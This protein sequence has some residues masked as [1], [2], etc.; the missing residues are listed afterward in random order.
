MSR[1]LIDDN[2]G[3]S[4]NLT[5]GS[6]DANFASL[7]AGPTSLDSLSANS[8]TFENITVLDTATI[9]LLITEQELK[10]ED[11]LIEFG[12][13]NP[14]DAVNLGIIEHYNDGAAKYTG[15]IRDRVTKKQYLYKDASVKPT[16]TTD[17]ST[18]PRGSLVCGDIETAGLSIGSQYTLPQTQ[19]AAGQVLT[20][21][22][23]DG[24]LSWQDSQGGASTLQE[25]YDNSTAPQIETDLINPRLT[26]KQ[27]AA[28]SNI[29]MTVA[30]SSGQDNIAMSANGDISSAGTINADTREQQG[31]AG[32]LARTGIGS[33]QNIIV[34]ED[35][36]LDYSILTGNVIIGDG[37]SKVCS[38]ENTVVGT[39]AGQNLAEGKSVLVGF[40]SGMEQT[41]GFNVAAGHGALEGTTGA[42]S[43]RCVAAGYEAMH[44][45]NTASDTVAIGHQA[46]F[47][48]NSDGCVLLGS[49]TSA[50]ADLCTAIGFGAS[51][52]DPQTTVIGSS[53][54]ATTALA[55]LPGIDDTTDLGAGNLVY[56]NAFVKQAVLG[57]LG[58]E[59]VLPSVRGLEGQTLRSLGANAVDWEYIGLQQAFDRGNLI[60]TDATSNQLQIRK[61]PA[62]PTPEL[63][64]LQDISGAQVMS[65][66]STGEL[67]IGM[68]ATN[69]KLPVAR[70]TDKQILQTDANGQVTW[71]SLPEPS[72][73]EQYF[74]GNIVVTDITVQNQYFV[75]AGTRVPGNLKDFVSNATDLEYTGAETRVMKFDFSA[76][77][78]IDDAKQKDFE[79]GIHKNGVLQPEGVMLFV[80]DDTNQYPRVICTSCLVQMDTNDT[81]DVRIRCINDVESALFHSISCN[82]TSINNDAGMTSVVAGGDVTGPSSSVNNNIPV[83]AGTTG[84]IIADG[85]RNI[86]EIYQKQQ[87]MNMNGNAITGVLNLVSDQVTVSTGPTA[88]VLPTVTGSTGQ[89]MTLTGTNQAGWVDAAVAGGDVV[90]PAS[91]V[92]ANFSMFDGVTGKLLQDSGISSG[93]I[94]NKTQDLF[95]NDNDILGIKSTQTVGPLPTLALLDEKKWDFT[96]IDS[97]LVVEITPS[98]ASFPSV[99]GIRFL[100]STLYFCPA[101]IGIGGF[102]EWVVDFTN[103]SGNN[104]SCG[105]TAR[106]SSSIFEGFGSFNDPNSSYILIQSAANRIIDRGVLT[107]PATPNTGRIAQPIATR[108]TRISA[109]VWELSWALTAGNIAQKVTYGPEEAG[110][111]FYLLIGDLTAP[112]SQFDAEITSFSSSLYDPSQYRY[113]IEQTPENSL[114][115]RDAGQQ[116]VYS[117]TPNEYRIAKSLT[118]TK[119]ICCN[120]DIFPVSCVR[121]TVLEA[122]LRT[123]PLV[124]ADGVTDI[125]DMSL[126]TRVFGSTNIP[127]SSP[128]LV[129]NLRLHG[130]LSTP[131]SS[132]ID[133]ILTCDINVGAITI[134][135]MPQFALKG[136]LND[137][138]WE[139]TLTIGSTSTFFADNTVFIN[140]IS[141]KFSYSDNPQDGG[142]QMYSLPL[143]EVPSVR[144]PER[145]PGL[146][147]VN[148]SWAS[149]VSGSILSVEL[150]SMQFAGLSI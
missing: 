32:V 8:A 107:V 28:A 93:A 38:L 126:Y 15:L 66:A 10:I 39:K 76:S 64:V 127:Q 119:N 4:A 40:Q 145:D 79:I 140:V 49:Q 19:G 20:D 103:V 23:G 61:G 22:N 115:C 3:T 48:T 102:V 81:I 150:V 123:D 43:E 42:T 69:Y 130:K 99:V 88:Y 26:V 92:D 18:L 85:L 29:V 104:Y 147:S 36:A 74:S 45:S 65:M 30:D 96:A 86:S 58:S 139:M 128:G 120:L 55:I 95:M 70:G 72:Y 11:P 117:A 77:V 83:F 148:C 37:A 113:T 50:A 118:T 112:A 63:L 105:M 62:D 141:G 110:K 25:A 35:N 44:L 91:S 114:I 16:T 142:S 73:G 136:L 144:I 125:I 122:Y 33:G 133:N 41:K 78:E 24:D 51:C 97:S 109:D 67:S 149:A 6:V 46:G 68:A 137:V 56:R 82:I 87:L 132:N 106:T 98:K 5:D 31:V 131:T 57:L 34:S 108:M 129:Y 17:I 14:A 121:T 75:I 134:A 124:A 12:V 90:G 84:K 138:D 1:F 21:V 135:T 13:N 89:V 116:E 100:P 143:Q 59:Y 47:A 54:P 101:Y 9:N 2:S 53:N 111:L 71:E 80:L 7:V 60:T 52:V 27:G 146:L 94:Y